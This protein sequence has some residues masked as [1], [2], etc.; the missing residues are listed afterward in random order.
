[1]AANVW[2]GH[3]TFGLVSLPVRLAVAA[4]SE[5]VS[6]NQLHKNDNSRVKQVLFCAAEDKQIERSEIVKGYEYEKG[7]YVVIDDEDIKKIQPKTAKVMEILEFVKS[8]EM[9]S[10]YLESSYYIQPEEA[11][12]KPYT[13]LF[14]ALRKS[15]YVGI[16]K[17]TMHQR[18]HTVIIRPGRYGLV[19]HK[20]YYQDEIRA[21]DEF[22]TNVDLVKDKELIMAQSLIDA[23]AA[24]FEPAKFKDNYRETLRTMIDAKIAG[25]EVVAAPQAEEIA[26]V[27]DIMEALRSSLEALKKPAVTERPAP[28]EV[29]EK[30]RA[31]GRGR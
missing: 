17:V 19:L 24:P 13:L 11:G 2:K 5:T 14:E 22:R 3:I 8:D 10:I 27:V 7:K 15:G 30:R 31:G 1:M 23:L 29:P 6:F 16:A 26:P 25:E 12:E 9:D 20:M 4:R 28:S 18:E 21:T